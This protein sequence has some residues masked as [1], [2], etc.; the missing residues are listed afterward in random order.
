M[1]DKTLTIDCP[2]YSADS[3]SIPV[4]FKDGPK[5]NPRR[6]VS[7]STGPALGRTMSDCGSLQYE[8]LTTLRRGDSPLTGSYILKPASPSLSDRCWGPHY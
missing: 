7:A 4:P 6:R 2:C 1:K 8:A 5:Y 3:V